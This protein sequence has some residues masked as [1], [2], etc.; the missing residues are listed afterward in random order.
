MSFKPYYVVRT[1][2]YVMNSS[3]FVIKRIFRGMIFYK[4]LLS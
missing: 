4:T 2:K 3:N 1:G